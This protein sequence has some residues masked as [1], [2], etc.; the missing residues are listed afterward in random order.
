MAGN[1]S[2]YQRLSTLV[3]LARVLH[4]SVSSTNFTLESTTWLEARPW[5]NAAGCRVL[6]ELSCRA[7]LLSFPYQV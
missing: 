1:P 6:I 2:V 5:E 7:L 3:L 4:K